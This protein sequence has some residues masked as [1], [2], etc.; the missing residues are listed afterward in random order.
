MGNFK[1]LVVWQKAKDLCVKIYKM[2]DSGK[3]KNDFDFKTL[4]HCTGLN[5]RIENTAYNCH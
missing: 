1:Q 5:I 4:F 3:I 2:T